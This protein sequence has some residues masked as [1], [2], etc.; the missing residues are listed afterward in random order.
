MR[1]YIKFEGYFTSLASPFCARVGGRSEIGIRTADSIN[2]GESQIAIERLPSRRAVCFSNPQRAEMNYTGLLELDRARGGGKVCRQQHGK[3]VG[4]YECICEY[5]AL[6]YIG[7]E[8]PLL[9][10][11]R[12]K[13][14]GWSL[15]LSPARLCQISLFAGWQVTSAREYARLGWCFV[16]WGRPT[17]QP[18]P[19][20]SFFP[21]QEIHQLFLYLK[22][23][24]NKKFQL[25]GFKQGFF[26]QKDKREMCH[27]YITSS[28]LY[29][30]NEAFF[31]HFYIFK[32]I[33]FFFQKICW[34]FQY[35]FIKIFVLVARALGG[36]KKS[37]P[38]RKWPDNCSM[39]KIYLV[40]FLNILN[41]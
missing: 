5:L 10:N 14:K 2:R 19:P 16:P 24:C 36:L 22:P 40:I 41:N 31:N 28:F 15:R 29:F 39:P 35:S 8:F 21:Q 9:H 17:A 38:Y 25:Y 34:S 37:F 20:F 26:V 7:N 32:Y 33:P 1:L 11:K 13:R 4:W 27:I 12:P 3:G 30:Y 23:T 6:A 18:H